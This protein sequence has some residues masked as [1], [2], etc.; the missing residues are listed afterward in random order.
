MFGV[1]QGKGFQLNCGE[2]REW[3]GHVC[4]MCLA[5]NRTA[6]SVARLTTNYDAALVSVLYEA[7]SPQPVRKVTHY[8]P[9]RRGCRGE[10]I[11]ADTP[12]AR[13]AA[14]IAMLSAATKIQ[15]HLT[16]RDT[17]LRHLPGFFGRVAGR[18]LRGARRIAGRLGFA[19]EAVESQTRRQPA[20]EAEP[21]RDFLF[22]AEPTEQAVGAACRHVAVL[23]G[24]PQQAGPLDRIGR[25]FGRIMY[26]I[27]AYRDREA[28]AAREKFNPL[29]HCF[30]A[31]EIPQRSRELFQT[32]HQEIKSLFQALDLPKPGL[33]RRLLFDQ[34]ERVG[35]ET[36]ASGPPTA[37]EAPG[38]AGA[39]STP[40]RRRRKNRQ[41]S[42]VVACCDSSTTFSCCDVIYCLD[43]ACSDAS[44]PDCSAA[45]DGGDVCSACAPG[46]CDVSC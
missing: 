34:L 30:S 42:A 26:L 14:S 38:D 16:D 37:G 28:D 29:T 1:I 36:L 19:T 32:A 2:R 10:V 5:L 21:G 6:G 18:W 25:L 40:G 39:P 22:Y 13:F 41:A 27:D 43:C 8:C 9:L 23:A 45:C 33:A 44:C 17:W 4:G 7:L 35:Q 15:D 12:G 24:C 31:A 11:A 20:V 3:M 46:G